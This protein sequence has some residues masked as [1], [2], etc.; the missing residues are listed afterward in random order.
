[1]AVEAG[2]IAVPT[3]PIFDRLAKDGARLGLG[4]TSLEKVEI[5]RKAAVE[6]LDTMRSA[7][8]PMAFG[9]DLLAD[10]QVQPLS[11]FDVRAQVMSPAEIL[12]L[13]TGVGARLCR[14]EG[15]I[16][17]IAPGVLADLLVVEGDPLKDIGVLAVP[18]GIG[19]VIARGAFVY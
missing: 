5:V 11:E 19:N 14:M 1:M 7:G 8:L 16:G 2:C 4:P 9:T 12:R 6:S 15:R 18:G 3:V 10:I 17:V 13:V